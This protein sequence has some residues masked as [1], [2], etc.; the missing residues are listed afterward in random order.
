MEKFK[1]Y[2][3]YIKILQHIKKDI[4]LL[5]GTKERE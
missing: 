4:A 2:G 1:K 3:L 5:V